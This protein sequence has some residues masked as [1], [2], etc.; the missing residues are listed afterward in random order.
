M[1]IADRLKAL[2]I[3]YGF[4]AERLIRISPANLASIL[5]ID[6]YIAKIIHNVAVDRLYQTEMGISIATTTTSVD[7]NM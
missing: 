4:T 7:N 1:S 3:D 6:E 2:L 5:G